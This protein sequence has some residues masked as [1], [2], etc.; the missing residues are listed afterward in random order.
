MRRKHDGVPRLSRLGEQQGKRVTS[1][2]EHLL[3]P[4]W[5]HIDSCGIKPVGLLH[6][7]KEV[8]ND[9]RNAFVSKHQT[10]RP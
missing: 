8:L 7:V 4:A 1:L 2:N 9:S 3:P 6:H 10:T 5:R